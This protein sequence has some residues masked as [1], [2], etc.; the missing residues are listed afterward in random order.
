MMRWL[1]PSTPAREL[2]RLTQDGR[3]PV[4]LQRRGAHLGHLLETEPAPPAPPDLAARWRSDRPILLRGILRERLPAQRRAIAA[5]RRAL[6]R[7]RQG[8]SFAAFVVR[9]LREHSALRLSGST[10]DLADEREI[11]KVYAR[12]RGAPE[13]YAKL[14]WISLDERDHSLRIRFSHG[15]EQLH[16]WWR[17]RRGM[18]AANRYADALFPECAAVMGSKPLRA[19]LGRLLPGAADLCERIVY[20][21]APH[22]GAVFHCDAE[23]TQRGVLFSQLQGATAWLAL[24]RRDLVACAARLLRTTP[25]RAAAQLDRD[26]PRVQELINRTPRFAALL[27]EH[28]AAFVVRAGDVMLLPN[29]GPARTCWHS[30]FAVGR[31]PTLA[32]SYGVFARV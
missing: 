3:A 12:V 29:H 1:P 28:G 8:G 14:S 24:P 23:P 20:N 16:D 6:E 32:H 27:V 21:N 26:A 15:V 13:L 22:G 10:V 30:V 9:R 19:L 18:R 7:M 2:R 11:E 25:V 5:T 4:A 31:A 17:D